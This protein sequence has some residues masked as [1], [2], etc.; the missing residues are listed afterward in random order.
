[1]GIP[2]LRGDGLGEWSD[3]GFDNVLI[4][5]LLRLLAKEV[6]SFVK[7]GAR[8]EAAVLP[9]RKV[10]AD[11]IFGEITPAYLV[12]VRSGLD[13]ETGL[14]AA[15]FVEA[16]GDI[17]LKIENACARDF[18]ES[19]HGHAGTEDVGDQGIVVSSERKIEADHVVESFAVERG[20]AQHVGNKLEYEA[21]L[22]EGGLDTGGIDVS[23]ANPA[24]F[25]RDP[26]L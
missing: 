7:G 19:I 16:D 3:H 18:Q 4:H 24:R 6:Q 12:G 13:H 14:G 10:H 23:A 15:V 5:D 2:L 1:M 21:M 25:E 22:L 9:D 26:A 11:L 17:G 8:F 20:D